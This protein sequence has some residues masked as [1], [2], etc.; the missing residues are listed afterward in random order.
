MKKVFYALALLFLTVAFTGCQKASTQKIVSTRETTKDGKTIVEATFSDG[1]QL[2]FT[3][4]SPNTAAVTSAFNFSIEAQYY[5][6]C[7]GDMVIP[8]EFTHNSQSYTVESI[9][10]G[11]FERCNK[12]KSIVI[13]NTV[14][15]LGWYAFE[16]CTELRTVVLPNTIEYIPGMMFFGCKSLKSINF[17]EKVEIIEGQAFSG[18]E[19]LESIRLPENVELIHGGAFECC[20][21]LTTVEMGEKIESIA[22]DAFADCSQLSKITMPSV[23]SISEGAFKNCVSLQSIELPANIKELRRG[24]FSG[25]SSLMS[26]TCRAVSPPSVV[27]PFPGCPIQEIKVP[28]ESVSNYK[29]TLGW[30]PYADKIVGY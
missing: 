22:A 16:E 2:Y 9:E 3:I 13:P 26:V 18:C 28:A 4:V 21:H 8:S 11:A 1:K 19:S 12:L 14:T 15:D 27:D 6:K 30:M 24:V 17:P 20:I 7:Y 5:W 25:C 23:N 10:N 29:T